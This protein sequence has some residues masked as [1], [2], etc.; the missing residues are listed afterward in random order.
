MSY[1]VNRTL[2]EVLEEMRVSVKT[3]NFALIPSLIE[4]VQCM[5]NRMEAALGDKKD[6]EA[7]RKERSRLKK[8]IK[9]LKEDR[10]D[11]VEN[12]EA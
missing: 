7:M 1:W 5:G 11:L 2:C 3:L 12:K 10:D 4:E 8:E 9:Q 6:V